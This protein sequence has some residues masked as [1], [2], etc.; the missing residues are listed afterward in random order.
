VKL[1]T[2][3]IAFSGD[4]NPILTK[5]YRD[6]GHFIELNGLHYRFTDEGQ[7]SPLLLLHGF[8]GSIDTWAELR[9]A[10]VHSF[11]VITVDLPG[12]GLTESPLDPARYHM[13]SAAADLIELC[14]RL[15]CEAVNLMGYSMGGR[16]ALYLAVHYP[17]LVRKLMLVSASPGLRTEEERA[18]RRESDASIADDI[19][20]DG[21]DAFV[22]R[23]EALPLFR[24]LQDLPADK[25]QQLHQQRLTNSVIGLANSLRGM[26][27]GEQP[28]L[29]E[30]LPG[31]NMPVMLLVGE[32]DAKF[33]A[34]AQDM[35]GL[36]PQSTIE[37]IKKSGHSL[38]YE[39]PEQV[40]EK[41]GSFLAD[42]A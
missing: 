42:R 3:L 27:T 16:L 21:I 41:V 7:G 28:S 39:Q 22:E 29:W 33:M 5:E 4:S 18:A 14:R 36:L 35:A 1:R 12:H 24:S 25:Q 10:L 23:W 30:S 8:T 2:I 40:I 32:W 34:I 19:E 20:R 38:H 26:G 11:R 31:L 9:P 17:G 37:I 6:M 15:D 13:E